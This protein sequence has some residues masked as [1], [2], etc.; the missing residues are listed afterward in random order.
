VADDLSAHQTAVDDSL[1]QQAAAATPPQHVHRPPLYGKRFA[2]AYVLL[3]VILGAAVGLAVVLAGEDTGSTGASAW[4]EWEPSSEGTTPRLKEITDHVATKYRLDSGRQ[5]VAV[6][7]GPLSV[8]A[9][10]Q[11]VSVTDIAIR[12]GTADG[13]V[14]DVEG[15]DGAWMFN[16]CGLGERCSI[17]EGQ[18]STERHLLLRRQALELAL[19]SF[20]YVDDVKS[21]VTFLPPAPDAETG[22]VLYLKRSDLKAQ[23]D[24]PL[25]TSLLPLERL[26]PSD[27]PPTETELID[28]LT[29]PRLY[30]FDFQQS[31]TGGAVMILDPAV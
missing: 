3:A 27:V 24:T 17:N 30:T 8:Q 12:S 2:L 14:I 31:P 22:T 1:V 4:S 19:Y 23:L 10:D 16:M 21:V 11:A 9:Q 5:L 7:A 18:A 28:T 29:K 25:G 20:H 13:D 6:D 15:A 26:T